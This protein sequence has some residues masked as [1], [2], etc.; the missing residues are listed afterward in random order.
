MT[1]RCLASLDYY[2]R[3]DKV[4]VVDDGSP[5]KLGGQNPFMAQTNASLIERK[6][7]GGF[8]AA[9][10]SGLKAATGDVLII[11]NND[12][13]FAENW[14]TELLK[15]LKDYD[16]SSIRVSDS[17][18]H[19][20]EDKITEGDKFGSL[21]AM[22]RK[23]YEKLGGLDESFGTGTFEDLDYYV[24]AKKAGFKIAKN[25]SV[26]VEHIGRATFDVV[27]PEKKNFLRNK[28]LFEKKH[29]QSL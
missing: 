4:I 29:G 25:H 14:L 13:I 10:N 27:D 17:D 5:L 21:W 28:K 23:V 1:E 24:R 26:A 15:P 3:P 2:G 11:S 7:N 18:G 8:P 6:T 12:I 20:T 19:E 22:K 9:V 16:I